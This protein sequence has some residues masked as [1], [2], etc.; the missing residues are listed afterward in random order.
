MH[1][2]AVDV[3]DCN[4][5]QSFRDIDG[6]LERPANR[7]RWARKQERFSAHTRCKYE[8][9]RTH[10]RCKQA[11][12]HRHQLANSQVNSDSVHTAPERVGCPGQSESPINL[13]ACR[14]L[15]IVWSKNSNLPLQQRRQPSNWSE[16]LL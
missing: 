11:L 12:I 6:E 3:C 1:S 14:S 13:D 16:P 5:R 2:T 15:Y 4:P 10:T 7:E 9:P 8:G